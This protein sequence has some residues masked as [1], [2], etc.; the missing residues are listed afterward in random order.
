MSNLSKDQ[1]RDLLADIR[2][3]ADASLRNGAGDAASGLAYISEVAD[4]LDDSGIFEANATHEACNGEGCYY[5]NFGRV[6]QYGDE[7][8]PLGYRN[9]EETN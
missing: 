9:P 5:C 1:M 8:N 6:R 2:K 3:V 4:L 7:E